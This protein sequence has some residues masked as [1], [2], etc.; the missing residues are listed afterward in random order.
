M[1]WARN[2]AWTE[3]ENRN[4][5]LAKRDPLKKSDFFQKNS[6]LGKKINVECFF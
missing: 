2:G 5:S 3:E 1:M 6:A 4:K